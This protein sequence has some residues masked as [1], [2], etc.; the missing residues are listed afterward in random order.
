MTFPTPMEGLVRAHLVPAL[1]A[2]IRVV[3]R[4][5][6]NLQDVLPV[7]QLAR[8]GGQDDRVSD[9]AHI[10]V[11]VYH[12]SEMDA[13]L[14]AERIRQLMTPGPAV[15]S[16]GVIDAVTTDTAPMAIPYDNPAV[17]RVTATYRVVARR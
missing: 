6:A 15:T 2:G 14:L 16:A 5:P 3:T 12:R 13:Y 1:G 9:I 11:V 17:F 8:I 4:T 7:V 10:D